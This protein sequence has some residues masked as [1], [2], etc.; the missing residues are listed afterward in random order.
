MYRLPFVVWLHAQA[1]RDDP[2]GD[3]ATDTIRGR[4]IEWPC[5]PRQFLIHLGRHHAC[6]A[7]VDAAKVAIEEWRS[8]CPRCGSVRLQNKGSFDKCLYCG[9]RF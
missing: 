3:L 8:G 4:G 7:A 2:I 6:D 5:S 1:Y 9:L